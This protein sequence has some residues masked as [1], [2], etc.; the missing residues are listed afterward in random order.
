MTAVLTCQVVVAR[1]HITI[2]PCP[3]RIAEAQETIRRE[4]IVLTRAI[5]AQVGEAGIVATRANWLDG[6]PATAL[7][8][9]R[10]VRSII[11][12]AAVLARDWEAFWVD[13]ATVVW[14]VTGTRWSHAT[15][16]WIKVG[17]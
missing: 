14:L 8:S 17:C 5:L 12:A 4:G 16:A 1:F 13:T 10:F 3:T 11:A 2:L 9:V 7:V 15:L 6:L